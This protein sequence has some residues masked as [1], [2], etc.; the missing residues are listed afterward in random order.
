MTDKTMT[1]RIEVFAG[2]LIAR[3]NQSTGNAAHTTGAL[4]AELCGLSGQ[5]W[6]LNQGI[7]GSLT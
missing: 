2:R 1:D 4:H 3:E 6:P 7:M 5:G